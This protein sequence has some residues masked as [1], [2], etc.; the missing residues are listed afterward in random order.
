MEPQTYRNQLKKIFAAAVKRVDPERMITDFLSLEEDLLKV[1]LPGFYH[2]VNLGEYRR[3]LVLGAGKATAK[4]AK[5]LERVL[6]NRIDDGFISVKRGHTEPLE[7]IRTNEAGHPVPDG[8]SLASAREVE[9]LAEEAD[10]TTFVINLISGGGSAL[11]CSPYSDGSFSLSLEE[12]QETTRALLACGAEIR[13]INCI[14]KHLSGIK[15]GRLAARL[16]PAASLNLILSDVIGDSLNAIASGLTAADPTTFAEAVA[17]LDKYQLW[18]RIPG[19]AERILQAGQAGKLRDTPKPGDPLLEG[20]TNIL[21]GTN[22]DALSVAAETARALGYHTASLTSRL[23]GEA[24]VGGGLPLE[25]RPGCAG[26]WASDQA[27][28]LSYS[29]RGNHGD[30]EGSG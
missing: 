29:W 6:G 3:I 13:E 22:R 21:I 1:S 25:H 14:R 19:A 18:G 15:G 11:L 4:M 17:I 12:K 26:P 8:E 30:P 28:R 23:S 7:I 10:K 5:A 27:S 9:R 24:P 16:N 20:G 2:E